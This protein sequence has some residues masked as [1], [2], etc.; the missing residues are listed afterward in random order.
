MKRT[1]VLPVFLHPD[2]VPAIVPVTAGITCAVEAG[3]CLPLSLTGGSQIASRKLRPKR[4]IASSPTVT[5]T[6]ELQGRGGGRMNEGKRVFVIDPLVCFRILHHPFSVRSAAHLVCRRGDC[7]VGRSFS[8]HFSFI[9][10]FGLDWLRS[11]LASQ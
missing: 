3:W 9:V 7:I 6:N 8:F 4:E 10:V 11:I 2:N 5:V 1:L